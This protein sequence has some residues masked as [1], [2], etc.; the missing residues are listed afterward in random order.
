MPVHIGEFEV[1]SPAA[2]PA[3]APTPGATEPA[4]V[5]VPPAQAQRLEQQR[6]ERALRVF[7]H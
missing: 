1:S 6:R 4:A 5:I 3:A 2:A 7:A